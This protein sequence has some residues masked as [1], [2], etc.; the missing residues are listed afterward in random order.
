M[1]GKNKD[2]GRIIT[3][4]LNEEEYSKLNELMMAFQSDKSNIMRMGLNRLYNV[5]LDDKN[6]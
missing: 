4:R 5:F 1:S 2:Y 6:K 3:L